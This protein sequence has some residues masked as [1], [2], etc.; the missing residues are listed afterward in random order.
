M[1]R[2]PTAQPTQV[3][4]TTEGDTYFDRVNEKEDRSSLP[5]G[6]LARSVNKRLRRKI[7]E[8]RN[9]VWPPVFANTLGLDEIKGFGVYSNPNGTELLL[10]ATSAAIYKMSEGSFPLQIPM[11]PGTVLDQVEFV[12]AHDK[13]FIFRGTEDKQLV[14]N[15][16]DAT[17]FA[18]ILK[19]DPLDTST[20]L[21]PPAVTA[22]NIADR[23]LIISGTN[24][25]I[26]TDILDYVSYDAALEV[27]HIGR[28]A[29]DT[30]VRVFNYAKGM[31]IVFCNRSTYILLSFAGDPSLASIEL[32]NS[33][34][35]LAGRKAAVMLGGDVLFLSNPGGIYRIAQSFESRIQTVPLPVTDPIQPFIDRINWDAASGAVAKVLGEYVYFAVPV[36]GSTR[37]NAVIVYNGASGLVEGYDTFPEPFRIDDFA[38]TLYERQR[39]LYALDKE[40]ARIYVMYEGHSDFIYDPDTDTTTE[41]EIQDLIETRGYATLG[42]NAATRRDF[43]QVQIGI[44]TWAPSI[45]VTELTESAND[46]RALN[47]NAITKSRT[48]YDTFGR[49]DWVTTNIN[50]DWA[51]PGRQDYSIVAN[52]TGF[53][54]DGEGIDPD[55]KQT[56]T[57]RFST[58]ARGKYISYR[59]ANSQGCADVGWILVESSGTQREPRRGG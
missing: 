26:A 39:R 42:W 16:V 5:V 28:E 30:I 53:V 8:T 59:V 52:D 27:F 1:P 21:I 36:D 37:N 32:L 3:Q 38:V 6:V 33:T 15:G 20:T 4:V 41:N 54:V 55:Q 19:T 2:Y 22:E 44:T 34:L 43:K 17:G 50:D 31:A 51:T 49:G 12:Q 24:D 25:I 46:E 57:L 35:G 48:Q 47:S 58:K 13:I 11:T 7:A 40:A 45:T 10:V 14:W 18:E 56:S 9:G 29:G 23:L